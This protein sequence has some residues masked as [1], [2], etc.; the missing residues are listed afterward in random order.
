[1]EILVVL[2]NIYSNPDLFDDE[3]YLCK[4]DC[5]ILSEA[6]GFKEQLAGKDVKITALLFAENVPENIQTL[7]KAGTYGVDEAYLIG[8]KNFDFSRTEELARVMAKTIAMHFPDYDYILFGRLAYDGDAVNIATQVAC[9]LKIPEMVYSKE[10]IV[11]DNKIYAKKVLSPSEEVLYLLKGKVLIQSF[12]EH[13]I[14][15]Q[16]KIADIIRTYQEMSF[17][18]IDGDAMFATLP[19]SNHGL[20]FI[21]QIIPRNDTQTEFTLLNDISDEASSRKLLRLLQKKG[22]QGGQ[23]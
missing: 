21:R 12:R 6:M 16:P 9:H 10:I 20:H 18:T 22:F 4:S 7:K 15:R 17:Q 19:H 13:G 8:F 23:L 2:R 11:S 14:T 3:K 1:M 5:N